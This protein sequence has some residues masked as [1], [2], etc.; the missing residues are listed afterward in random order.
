MVEMVEPRLD[1]N[2]A[3]GMDTEIEPRLK[4]SHELWVDASSKGLAKGLA[5][6]YGACFGSMAVT[7]ASL[8]GF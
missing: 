5:A 6:I 2:R 1:Q 8:L 3:P 7:L 4:R